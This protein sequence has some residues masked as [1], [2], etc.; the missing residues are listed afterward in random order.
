MRSGASDD[1]LKKYIQAAVRRKK[2]SHDGMFELDRK[3]QQ[4]RPMILIGG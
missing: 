3:K 4:N 1:E 2:P